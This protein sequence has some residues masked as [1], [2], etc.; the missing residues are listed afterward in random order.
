MDGGLT[1]AWSGGD[2]DV[3]D[4]VT[5]DLHW[6]TDPNNLVLTAQDIGTTEYTMTGLSRG[7]FY[8]WQIISR[9]N[10]GLETT[11]PVW[12]FI[13]DGDDPDLIVSNVAIS[14]AEQFAG[15]GHRYVHGRYPE[16]TAADLSWIHLRWISGLTALP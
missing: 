10:N 14:P 4:T 11:G 7:V 13:S 1:L 6:G 15:R 3:L 12:Q 8:Y 2:P 16:M 5:Y 9:D